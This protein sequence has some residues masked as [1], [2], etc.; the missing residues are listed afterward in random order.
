MKMHGFQ[1]MGLEKQ[2]FKNHNAKHQLQ[3]YWYS[4]N[5]AIT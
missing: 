4:T 2:P 1:N 3:L 5:N